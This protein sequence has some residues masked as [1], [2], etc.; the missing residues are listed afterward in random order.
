MNEIYLH[1]KI[2]VS[3]LKDKELASA[4]D[5]YQK[6]TSET[7]HAQWTSEHAHVS[8]ED[9]DVDEQEITISVS[10]QKIGDFYLRF[11]LS[12]DALIATAQMMVKKVNKLKSVLESL[13]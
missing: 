7:T 8:F 4:I 2:P 11:I 13:K 12:D 3:T 9:F 10:D 1:V 5:D 6:D